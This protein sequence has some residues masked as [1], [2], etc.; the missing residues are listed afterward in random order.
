MK[1]ARPA[2]NAT[3][4]RAMQS[5]YAAAMLEE[6]KTDTPPEIPHGAHDRSR[7]GQ[8][9]D[10]SLSGDGAGATRSVSPR[11]SR[12]RLHLQRPPARP[13]GRRFSRCRAVHAGICAHHAGAGRPVSVGPVGSGCGGAHRCT[14]NGA[15]LPRRSRLGGCGHV[16][17]GR[18]R[19]GAHRAHRHHRR[20]PSRSLSRRPR[21]E[22][23]TPQRHLAR[24]LLSDAERR[25]GRGRQRL[26]LSRALVAGR[27]AGI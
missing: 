7:N 24:L 26:R 19:P 15:R 21:H 8:R 6:L 27:L 10:V 16:W 13:G 18:A 1:R 3:S 17:R 2:L 23:R 4:I 22:L 5:I 25:A 20:G 14:G 9:C 12:Q 11:V